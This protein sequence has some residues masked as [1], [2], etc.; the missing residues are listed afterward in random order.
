VADTTELKLDASN[1]DKFLG[2]VESTNKASKELGETWKKALLGEV[3]VQGINR[4]GQAIGGVEGQAV[5]AAGAVAQGFFMGGPAGAAIAAFTIGV[6]LAADEFDLMGTRAEAAAERV[7]VALGQA[8]EIAAATDDKQFKRGMEE[9]LAALD[10]EIERAKE[11]RAKADAEDKAAREA[12]KKRGEDTLAYVREQDE[13][14]AAAQSDAALTLDQQR[15]QAF[16]DEQAAEAERAAILLEMDRE[17]RAARYESWQ[18]DIRDFDAAQ[19]VERDQQL[20]LTKQAAE[21]RLKLEQD[22]AKKLYAS[23]MAAQEAV[24]AMGAQAGTAFAGQIGGAVGALAQLDAAQIAAAAS[25]K[26]LGASLAS[27]ALES[28]QGVLASVAQEATVKAAL[29]TAKGIGALAGVGTAPLAPGFFGEAAAFAGVAALAG[30]GAIAAGTAASAVR[31]PPAAPAA[32]AGAGG[33]TGATGGVSIVVNTDRLFSTE[34][35]IGAAVEKSRRDFQRY[36]G[37]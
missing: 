13:A 28:V 30:G 19:A 15:A 7:R 25:S 26:D 29:A 6:G 24:L 11:V 37:V 36:R 22:A 4:V 17:G 23:R 16:E 14:L 20:A 3:V 9:R 33:G 5:A 10:L 32:L 1:W 8:R 2:T 27:A 21:A 12:N 34:A 35:E 31:P 18:Q